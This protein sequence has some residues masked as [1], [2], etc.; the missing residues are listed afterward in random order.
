MTTIEF[1]GKTSDFLKIGVAAAARGDLDAVRAILR[2]K[3]KWIHQIGSHGRTMLWEAAHRGQLEMVKYLVR[4]KADINACGTHYTPYFVDISCYCIA[5]FK[6]RHAVADFLLGKGAEL[7]IHTAAFLGNLDGVKQFLKKSR[8]LLNAGHDQ[9]MM[10]E[11]GSAVNFHMTPALWATPL[12]YALRGADEPTVEYLIA[13]G[14]QIKGNE[15]S[16]FIAA[17]EKPSLVRLLLENGADRSF[18]PEANPDDSELYKIVSAY[19]VKKP[20]EKRCSEELVYLCRG[21]RGGNKDEVRRWLKLGADVNYQ[22]QKGKTALHRAAKAGFV[23]VMDLLLSAGAKVDV[24]DKVGET[25]LFDVVRSTI[26]DANKKQNALRILLK[27]GAD[28][29]HVNRRGQD[30][31]ILAK[32]SRKADAKDL[33]RILRR[34]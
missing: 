10:A 5:R 11:K 12:V 34:K 3:P 30:A 26:K 22:D 15:R 29:T 13:R 2:A 25:A 1:T 9:C 28:R 23:E 20:S 32:K 7:D 19:G 14:A 16:L 31:L 4:R 8:K 17:N 18:A 33:Y 24:P 27:A 21:D 6:K